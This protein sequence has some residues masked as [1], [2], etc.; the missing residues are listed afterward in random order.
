MQAQ[1]VFQAGNSSVVAIPKD[2][3]KDLK[4]KPGQK[5]F[6]DKSPDGAAIVIK[7]A[8]PTINKNKKSSVS[9]EFQKWLD[10]FMKENGEILDELA[11]R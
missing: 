9:A 10:T 2:L 8:A 5:V 3:M 1:R 6:V 4:I 7:K 11:V